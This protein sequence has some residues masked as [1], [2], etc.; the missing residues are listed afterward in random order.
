ETQ[1][2][3]SLKRKISF[4]IP[5]KVLDQNTGK[6]EAYFKDSDPS[7]SSWKNGRILNITVLADSLTDLSAKTR[8]VLHSDSSYGTCSFSS[9]KDNPFGFRMNYRESLDF[10]Q[11]IQEKGTV[12]VTYT[13]DGKEVL[14]DEIKSKSLEFT[15]EYTQPISSYDI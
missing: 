15:G 14:D 12:P 6:I 13:F 3:G 1:D 7:W 5:Q 9:S 2:D 10:S 4:Y 11:F 8:E